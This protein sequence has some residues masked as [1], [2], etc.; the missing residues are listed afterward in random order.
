[1]QDTIILQNSFCYPVL[2]DCALHEITYAYRSTLSKRISVVCYK[3]YII[4]V[5]QKNER[6]I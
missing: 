6:R 5:A 1:M 3:C 4:A 2:R